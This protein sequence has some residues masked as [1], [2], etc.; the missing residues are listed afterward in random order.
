MK[1]YEAVQ[2][3]KRMKKELHLLGDSMT[4]VLNFA[5]E[6]YFNRIIIIYVARMGLKLICFIV[7][8]KYSAPM[9][10]EF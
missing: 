8:Y 7:F 6:K 1:S 9:A 5:T 4:I 3:S 2:S 10:L